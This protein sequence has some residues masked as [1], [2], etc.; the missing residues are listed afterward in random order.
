MN[1][2]VVTTEHL[3]RGFSSE[4]S[5]AEWVR[6]TIKKELGRERAQNVTVYAECGI[7][8]TDYFAISS[9]ISTGLPWGVL[10]FSF[11]IGTLVCGEHT[12]S[13]ISHIE[14]VDKSGA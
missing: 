7:I 14:L 9:R 11:G 13:D 8:D 12:L 2:R 10:A 6:R 5:E 3:E 1:N 4:E